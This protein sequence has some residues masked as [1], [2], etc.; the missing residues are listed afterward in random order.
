MMKNK[1]TLKEIA[2]RAG[3]S[4][5]TASNVING[6]EGHY[7]PDTFERVMRIAEEVGYSPNLAAKHL[8]KGALGLIGIVLPDIMNPYF[9]E[10][11]Q[12]AIREAEAH[13]YTVVLSFT[14]SDPDIIETFIHGTQQMPV[15]GI[16]LSAFP[17]E[18]QAHNTTIPVVL[19]GEQQAPS[20][21][22]NI[23]LDNAGLAQGATEHLIQLGRT[24]IAPIGVVSG[25]LSGMAQ[26]RTEGYLLAMQAAGLSVD[27]AW[28]VAVRTPTFHADQGAYVMQRLLSLDNKPHAVFC[29][30]DP[31]AFGAMKVLLEK[32]YRI[33][34]DVAVIGVDDIVES[35]YFNPSLSTIAIDR[36]RIGMLAVDLLIDRISG[37]R[38]GPP[39]YFEVPFT[40]VPRTSTIGS[41]YVT[42]ADWASAA[43]EWGINDQ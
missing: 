20:P 26:P 2:H 23:I 32:G 5:M 34:D 40:L 37:R 36:Q 27:P 6:K 1:S 21:F 9:S 30:N 7:S 31:I 3:V 39:E 42:N 22:D 19:L 38:N 33:P 16:I 10:L 41:Q 4:T 25:A 18:I 14:H 17:L 11:S 13:D 8:R 12:R 28:L 43:N 35:R 15:D 29:F 24:K